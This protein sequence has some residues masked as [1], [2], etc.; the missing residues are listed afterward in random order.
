[1]Y[2]EGNKLESLTEPSLS[3]ER[4]WSASEERQSLLKAM[5]EL[6]LLRVQMYIVKLCVSCSNNTRVILNTPSYFEEKKLTLL[7]IIMYINLNKM[8][9]QIVV[10]YC[11]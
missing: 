4:Q 2:F 8:N 11:A 9:I 3:L 10:N 5:V 1:M 6:C 7:S